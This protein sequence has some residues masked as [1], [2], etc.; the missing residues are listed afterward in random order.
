[1]TE[2]ASV[3]HADTHYARTNLLSLQIP[4]CKVD[5]GK[6]KVTRINLV[7]VCVELIAI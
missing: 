6:K 7:S 4:D 3:L 5:E 2:H 1:M